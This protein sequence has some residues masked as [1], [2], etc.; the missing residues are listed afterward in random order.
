MKTNTATSD[1]LAKL[2]LEFN[3]QGVYGLQYILEDLYTDNNIQT[4]QEQA[5]DWYGL[6]DLTI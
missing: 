5:P 3:N 6:T 2:N 4:Q 1:L